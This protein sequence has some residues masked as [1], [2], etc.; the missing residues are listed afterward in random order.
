[1][2]RIPLPF[3]ALFLALGASACQSP[4]DS[5]PLQIVGRNRVGDEVRLP[6]ASR[7]AA[8]QL[9]RSLRKLDRSTA[10]LLST[11]EVSG[12]FELKRVTVGLELELEAGLANVLE[13]GGEGVIE[14]RYERLPIAL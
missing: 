12:G 6:L 9:S 3:I 7:V 1:M 13:L 2:F 8:S 14:L 11:G 10:S 4:E 5:G